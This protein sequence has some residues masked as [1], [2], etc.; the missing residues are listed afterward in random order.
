M[1]GDAAGAREATERASQ[2]GI[3]IDPRLLEA[4]RRQAGAP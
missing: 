4:L 2:H 3:A 1:T